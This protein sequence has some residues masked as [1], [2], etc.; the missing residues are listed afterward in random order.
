VGRG[1]R[2]RPRGAQPRGP[3]V[4]PTP[5]ISDEYENFSE[6]LEDP[7]TADEVLRSI[8]DEEGSPFPAE[9]NDWTADEAVAVIEQTEPWREPED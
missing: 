8:I 6:R 2:L 7:Q 3:R 1:A 4:D 5:L 9:P